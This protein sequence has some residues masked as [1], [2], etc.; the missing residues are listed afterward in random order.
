MKNAV[1]YARY[2]SQGQNEQSIEGQIRICNEYAENNGYSVVKIYTDKARTEGACPL[3]FPWHRSMRF[4][5]K[6]CSRYTA[7]CCC[8][9]GCLRR[10]L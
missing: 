2:S 6:Y 3:P 4:F 1:I 7:A 5:A 10:A 9:V 8:G